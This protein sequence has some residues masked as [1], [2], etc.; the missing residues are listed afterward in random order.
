MWRKLH[1]DNPILVQM[2]GELK[3]ATRTSKV[4]ASN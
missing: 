2:T 4:E 3:Y 1:L